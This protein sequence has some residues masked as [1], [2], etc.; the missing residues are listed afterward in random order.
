MREHALKKPLT[1]NQIE[2]LEEHVPYELLMLRFTLGKLRTEKHPLAWNAMLESFA[3]HAR[4]LYSFLA[5]KG[6]HQEDHNACEFLRIT[7]CP[8]QVT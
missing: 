5:N 8:M 6:D 4:N 2:H 7:R 3:V 1:D